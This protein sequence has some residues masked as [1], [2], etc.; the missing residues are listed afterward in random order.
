MFEDRPNGSTAV[1]LMEHEIEL[2]DPQMTPIKQYPYR[3]NPVIGEHQKKKLQEM[4]DAGVIVPSKSAWASPIVSVPKADGTLRF[5]TD[6]RRLNKVIKS[7]VFP[8]PLIDVELDKCGGCK[9]FSTLDMRDAFHQIPIKKEHR[10]LTAFVCQNQLNE[11]A[12]SPF[13]LKTSPAVFQ[14]NMELV[15]QG[16][17]EYCSAYLDDLIIRSRTKKEHLKHIEDVLRRCNDHNLQMKLAKCDF[18]VSE[19]SYLGF[20]IGKDGVKVNQKKVEAIA[21]I[22]LPKNVK[23]LRSFL[24]MCNYYRRF[25]ENYSEH[26]VPLNRLLR[27]EVEFVFHEE[28]EIAFNRLKQM[29]SNS[30]VLA[31]PDYTRRFILTTDACTLGIGGVLSQ[32]F[33]EGERPILFM[34]RTLNEHEKN[35]AVTHLE[36]LAIVWCIKEC[37]HYLTGTK[38]TIRTDH[39]ALK[40]LMTTKDHTGRL[41]RWSLLLME[42]DFDIE[43]VKG[44]ENVVADALSRAPIAINNVEEKD[45]LDIDVFVDEKLTEIAEMQQEDAELLPLMQYMTT[46][47]LMEEGILQYSI[48]HS[49]R[50]YMMQK[51]V[52][53]HLWQQSK[54]QPRMEMVKQLVVPR[55]MRNEVMTVCHSD[56]M[57]GHYGV[58][59]TY[60]R[61]R[62]RFYWD[63]MF[64][65]CDEFVKSCDDCQ[66][67]KMPRF[68]GTKVPTSLT[69]MQLSH[70]PASDW[71]VDLMGPLPTS[72]C[73]MK[74]ICV[75]MDRFTRWPEAFAIPDKR[76]ARLHRCFL[77]KLYAS[78]VHRE[79]CC[80][81]VEQNF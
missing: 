5:C 79:H 46:G 12:K 49:S 40:W 57:A 23:E 70:E 29:L 42:F 56:L 52:L 32:M 28:C 63:G 6:F 30:P 14:R 18:F 65:D 35:Y 64:K 69:H 66:L 76:A 24:G 60:E 44:K 33:E 16:A 74:Y 22:A 1:G 20:K 13:G 72:D 71:A 47:E 15:I 62:E 41:M 61:V 45:V 34:S 8:L 21:R 4:L 38:F 37:Q 31:S 17:N 36:C 53:Y 7:D 59:R 26:A 10:H 27:K 58:K 9:Y 78:L 43:Y 75:F 81:I 48:V 73:G 3:V 55:V 19:V 80:Q 50:E 11:Y 54:S 39:H 2:T 77:R 25:I 68:T 67:K 51:G